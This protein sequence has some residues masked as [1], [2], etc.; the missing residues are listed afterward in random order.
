MFQIYFTFSRRI[1]LDAV[2][3]KCWI[4]ISLHY[5]VLTSARWRKCTICVVMQSTF[6]V[7][8]RSTIFAKVIRSFLIQIVLSYTGTSDWDKIQHSEGWK[9]AGIYYWTRPTDGLYAICNFYLIR[10]IDSFYFNFFWSLIGM[11]CRFQLG[12]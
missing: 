6:F 10:S 3:R 1:Q 2:R 4:F 7:R 12:M 9:K 5:F 8:D 11:I